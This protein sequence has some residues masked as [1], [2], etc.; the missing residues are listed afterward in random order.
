MFDYQLGNAVTINVSGEKGKVIGQ[1]KY[2]NAQDQ[3]LIQYK[4]ATGRAVE[5][6]WYATDVTSDVT[7]G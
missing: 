3:L 7:P 5:A 1:A 2:L 4:D 6:W